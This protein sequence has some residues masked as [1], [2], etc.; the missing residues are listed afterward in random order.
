MIESCAGTQRLVAL[1]EG[2]EALGLTKGLGAAEARARFPR[3][4]LREADAAADARLLEAVAD[5]CDRYTPLVALDAPH[6]L[7]LDISGCAHLFGGEKALMDDLLAR[8]FAQGLRAE[9]A[10]ASH[11]GTALA[12][13]GAR[14]AAGRDAGRAG[15]H[16]RDGAPCP[17]VPE[18]EEVAA[19]SPLPV[20]ALRLSEAEEALLA[21]L[22]LLDI[23]ALLALPRAGLARRFGS[24][25]LARL[26]EATGLGRR[27]IGPRRP[28][29][30]LIAERR[31]AEPISL[32]DDVERIAEHLAARLRD[33]LERRGEGGR[34]F[35]LS[36]FRAD[37]GVERV[38]VSAARPL[39]DERRV[40]ALLRERIKGLGEAFDAAFGY[41]LVRLCVLTAEPMEEH[42]GDLSGEASGE[43]DLSTLIDR[44][45]ARL[46]Q[47]S[48]LRLSP[49][50]SHRP[51][52]AQALQVAAG[53]QARPEPREARRAAGPGGG[54][55]ADLASTFWLYAAPRPVRLLDPPEPVEAIAEV[56]EGPPMRFRWRRASHGVARVEGPERIGAEWWRADAGST[57][58]YYRVEDEAGRR[59]WLFREG[60]YG[61]EKP[62]WFLHGIF[63]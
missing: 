37:G 62:A 17:R 47:T 57:R 16:P 12:L 13:T 48:V 30:Q 36:L 50:E 40:V 59:Y 27:P 39:R 55:A 41:D 11:P 25:L 4:D 60:L 8:L 29:A 35:E 21:R 44:L 33:G 10:I 22:G 1:C 51:E 6:G 7:V 15:R 58:D 38:A 31:F 20:S 2:A 45:G 49:I 5:W 3:L 18:G 28:A 32:T 9:A 43:A 61:Q 42:Q 46:G 26:D 34:C 14:S 24:A 54:R 19:V 52:R 56:P 53:L 23:G 63:A